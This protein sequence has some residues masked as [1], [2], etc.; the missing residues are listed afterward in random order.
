ML[1]IRSKYPTCDDCV[2][3]PLYPN[4]NNGSRRNGAN[5][6]SDVA[7]RYRINHT[8]HGDNHNA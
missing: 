6:H 7:E 4:D 2:S 5:I 3:T 1:S 8:Y